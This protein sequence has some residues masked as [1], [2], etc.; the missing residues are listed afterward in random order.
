MAEGGVVAPLLPAVAEGADVSLP[1]DV[2][3]HPPATANRKPPVAELPGVPVGL[4]GC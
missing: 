2:S 3:R 4:A 1:F